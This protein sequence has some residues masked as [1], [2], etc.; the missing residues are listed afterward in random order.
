LQIKVKR[1]ATPIKP[2]SARFSGWHQKNVHD[3]YP[4]LQFAMQKIKAD[5]TSHTLRITVLLP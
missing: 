4:V 3:I 1:K 2:K 5:S